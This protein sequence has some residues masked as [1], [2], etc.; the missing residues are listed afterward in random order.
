MNMPLEC[1]TAR[2][3][4]FFHAQAACEQKQFQ[5]NYSTLSLTGTWRGDCL[6]GVCMRITR[7]CEPAPPQLKGAYYALQQAWTTRTGPQERST[8]RWYHQPASTVECRGL[9]CC[10]FLKVEWS[11]QFWRC[12]AKHNGQICLLNEP[13][14]LYHPWPQMYTLISPINSMNSRLSRFTSFVQQRVN[15]NNNNE[16]SLTHHDNTIP[17]Q[18]TKMAG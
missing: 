17:W 15:T 16:I 9:C 7:D 13:N 14:T 6:A 4:F 12:C 10:S 5:Y 2:M 1:P 3:L 8:H 18:M 11:F